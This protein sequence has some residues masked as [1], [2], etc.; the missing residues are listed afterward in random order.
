MTWSLHFL[1]RRTARILDGNGQPI[2][3]YMDWMAAQAIVDAHN[4]AISEPLKVKQ[5][6]ETGR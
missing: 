1:D 2:S 6:Q 3:G 4:R 5:E